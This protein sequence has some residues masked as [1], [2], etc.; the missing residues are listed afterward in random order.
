M[1]CDERAKHFNV[2]RH[3]MTQLLFVLTLKVSFSIMT[4]NFTYSYAL[5]FARAAWQA[6]ADPESFGGGDVILN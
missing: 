2:H 3:P 6:G 4:K 5:G 1:V